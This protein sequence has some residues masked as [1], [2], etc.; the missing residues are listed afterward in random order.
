MTCVTSFYRHIPESF[1]PTYSSILIA[2][3]VSGVGAGEFVLAML[4]LVAALFFIGHMFYLR[5]VPRS[6]G[7][8]T[9]EGR[10]KAAVMLF[11]SLWSIILIVVLII[12][13]D[14]PVYVAT[15]MAAVLNIFVDHLK[16][17]EI[18]PM[19]RT[20]FEPIIIFNTILIMMFKDIITYTGV[21]HELPVF[22]GGLPIPL[23]MVFALI[24]F[25]GTII[26]GSNAII[27][28]CMPMAMAAMPDA[29]VPLLVLLMSSAYA[30]MQV[31]P[32]HVCLFIAAECFKVDI[33]EVK[34]M[35]TF[36]QLVRK[37]RQTSVKKSTAPALQ[38]GYNSLQKKATEV[39]A[40]QKRGVCTAV[41][42]ATP[43]KPNSALRKIA[44]VR[45]S[46]GI[47]VTSYIP[48]EGHNLQEHS[49]VLIRGGRVKD[50]PGTRYHI[51][52]GTLDTAGVANR[53]QAR[54]KYGA[55]R[56]KEKK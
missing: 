30:A 44:R 7:Q 34:R 17:W 13:F 14:I 39:S 1:L 36:N 42:T 26:S 8:K 55:K 16:P 46:N 28:L 20:A 3:A 19:F 6:T 32:T 54:S 37:G 50:L 40:P 25:F 47:E 9:E 45:L 24:F 43:K 38:R 2:L 29:G 5:K 35:P 52:R 11:K 33:E 10:K 23:P 22:F 49:V 53:R 4:P 15:P 27:P 48:G 51:V 41:K 18:K 21:I 56:P 31:S 12:A